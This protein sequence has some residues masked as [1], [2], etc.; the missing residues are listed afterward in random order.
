[1][2]S[3]AEA[4][5]NNTLMIEEDVDDIFQFEKNISKVRLFHP[6]FCISFLCNIVILDE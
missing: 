3:L 2:Y 6:K 5:T 4:L 1:M